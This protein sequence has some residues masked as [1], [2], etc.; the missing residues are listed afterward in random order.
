MENLISF[1][2]ALLSHWVALMSGGIS[3][4][5]TF[6]FRYR[7]WEPGNKIFATISALCLLFACYLAWSDEHVAQKDAPNLSCNIE[8]LIIGEG[9]DT[10]ALQIAV[11]LSVRNVGT[12]P[13]LAD[14]YKLHVKASDF[15]VSLLSAEI[16]ADYTVT[17]ADKSQK[18]LLTRQDS[19]VEKTKEPIG[20]GAKK[21]GWLRFNTATKEAM[22]GISPDLLKRPGLNYTVSVNDV[23]GKV[24]SATHAIQDPI[25]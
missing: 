17:S 7:H 3:L 24:C 9:S 21:E 4:V 23:R 2:W 10:K 22:P 8:N 25:K 20:Q 11:Q 13:S 18:I 12:Q 6:I 5:L 14:N 19:L 1:V 16:T 15:E